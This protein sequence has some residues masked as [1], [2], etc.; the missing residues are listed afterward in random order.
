MDTQIRKISLRVGTRTR[1]A[2]D[3]DVD[4]DVDDAAAEIDDVVIVDDNVDG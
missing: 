1:A 3:V 4:V 2:A